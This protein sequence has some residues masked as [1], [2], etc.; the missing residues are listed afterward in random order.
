M[1]YNHI[2]LISDISNGFLL[3]DYFLH[4]FLYFIF[5]YIHTIDQVDS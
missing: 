5:L 4:T 2:E 3:Y 1:K